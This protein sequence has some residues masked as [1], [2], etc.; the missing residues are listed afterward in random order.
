MRRVAV[1]GCGGAGKSTLARE[2]G[3][4]LDLP[5]LHLDEHYWRPG[6]QRAGPA[7]WRQIQLRLVAGDAWIIDGNYLSTLEL[8]LGAAD[9]VV[10]LDVS[11]WRCVWRATRRVLIGRGRANTAAGCPERLGRRHLS[12]LSY[13]WSFKRDARPGVLDALAKHQESTTVIRLATPAQARL[14]LTDL[15]R[16]T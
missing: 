7:V 3:R 1:I 12:F 6:W 15:A 9:T 8:R 16:K 13:I 14:F 10:F 5:V 11:R 2:L 4:R